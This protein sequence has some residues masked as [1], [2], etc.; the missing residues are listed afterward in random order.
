MYEAIEACGTEFNNIR[1]TLAA[2][3]SR[4]KIDGIR[5]ALEATASRLAEAQGNNELDRANLSKLY[6]GFM[7]ASR[8]VAHLYEVE[9]AAGRGPR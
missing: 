7:A 2:H 5:R 1:D 6:R 8:V 3:D 4:A 9:V